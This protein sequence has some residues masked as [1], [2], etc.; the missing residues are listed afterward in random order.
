M[1]SLAMFVFGSLALLGIPGLASPADLGPYPVREFELRLL[2]QARNRRV[3]VLLV[4]P[5]GDGP[6]PWVVFSPGFLLSGRDYRLLGWHLASHR[7]AVALLTYDV[8]LFNANHEVL[9]Q[10]L[11]FALSELLRNPATGSFLDSERIGLAGHSLGGKLSFLAAAEEARVLAIAALDPVDGGGGGGSDPVRFPRVTPE[12]MKLVRVPVLLLGAELGRLTRFGMPCAPEADNYQRFFQAA[13]PPALEIT[14]LGVGHM[15]YLDNPNCGLLCAVC[16]PGTRPWR[17]SHRST[18]AY[19]TLFFRAHLFG[20][21][22]ALAGLR[23]WVQAEADQ[24]LVKVR[25]K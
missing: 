6:F 10:D 14:Q 25:E 7:I 2:D 5:E 16:V 3:E 23:A 12:R 20:E 13:N 22:A 11:R 17:D 19:L 8:N 18:Y 15:D 9:A 24:G 21:V 1:K 4:L